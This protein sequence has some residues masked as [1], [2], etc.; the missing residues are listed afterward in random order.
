MKNTPDYNV[1][2]FV[3][4][5]T[6]EEMQRYIE[7]LEGTAPAPGSR[8]TILL[9]SATD[10]F[11]LLGFSGS[12]PSLFEQISEHKKVAL[13]FSRATLFKFPK[14]WIGK[15]SIGKATQKKFLDFVWNLFPSKQQKLIGIPKHFTGGAGELWHGLIL[16]IKNT[17]RGT[18]ELAGLVD[19]LEQRMDQEHYLL[20]NMRNSALDQ[21]SKESLYIDLLRQHTLLPKEVI[22]LVP[23]LVVNSSVQLTA[24]EKSRLVC[25]TK[26]DFYFSAIACLENGWLDK[27]ASDLPGLVTSRAD[28]FQLGII[29]TFII[30]IRIEEDNTV[31]IEKPFSIYLEWLASEIGTSIENNKISEAKLASFIPL[32]REEDTAGGYSKK[33]KQKDL[34]KNWKDSKYPSPKKFYQFVENLRGGLTVDAMFLI[35]IGFSAIILDKLFL[36]LFFGLQ[37]IGSIDSYKAMD[38]C[39]TRYS[40]YFQHYRVKTDRNKAVA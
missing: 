18:E 5:N 14:F 19:F 40:K 29:Q 16:G 28:W 31:R 38:Q 35:D 22:N 2:E 33:E 4:F 23:E 7:S 8:V 12:V 37:E 13:P 36:E 21:N 30:G 27:F 15:Q 1:R 10:F 25:S 17:V 11:Q 32:D 9:P 20:M 26:L 39:I 3:Y 6:A 34:L 24:F